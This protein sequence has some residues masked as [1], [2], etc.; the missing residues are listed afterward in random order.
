M[1]N[2][3]S[4]PYKYPHQSIKEIRS[5]DRRMYDDTFNLLE[6]YGEDSFKSAFNNLRDRVLSE[7]LCDYFRY[8]EKS[9][10]FWAVEFEFL[11]EK[12]TDTGYNERD[13]QKYMFIYSGVCDNGDS[14]VS[15]NLYLLKVSRR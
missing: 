7:K 5:L 6:R 8:S 12:L 9:S 15:P 14:L 11:M 4:L 1:L 3:C 2:V 13:L 10:I